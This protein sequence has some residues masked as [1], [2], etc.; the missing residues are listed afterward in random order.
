MTTCDELAYLSAVDALDLFR[1]KQLSPVELMTA[2]VERAEAVEPKINAFTE[3]FFDRALE[4]A[5]AAADAYAGDGSAARPLEGIAVAIKDE[6]SVEGLL[7]TEGSLVH[8]GE[9]ATAT[10][11]LAQ[12]IFDAGGIMHAR[13]TTPEFC[14]VPFT[15][16][17]MWGVTVSPW[18]LSKSAGGS[19]GGSGAAL[20]AGTTT[21][22]TGS[23]IG[24]SIRIPAAFCGVVGLKPSYGR[25]PDVTPWNLDHYCQNGPMA[26]TVADTALL[27]DVMQGP[28]PDD[29][30]TLS[31]KLAVPA[32]LPDVS[33]WRVAMCV[34]LG[35]YEVERGIVD[36]L[37]A[38]ADLLR[39]LGVTVD[40]VEL[41]W[42][43]EQ[44]ETIL[45]AHFGHIAGASAASLS[46]GKPELLNDYV[47]EYI[48]R[49]TGRSASMTMAETFDAETEFYRPLA[50]IFSGYRVL[51][52]PTLATVSLD[53]G[54]PYIGHGPTINGK[55]TGDVD[56]DGLMTGPFNIVG[57]CPSTA[58]PSGFDVS[59]MP[60][61]VQFVARPYHDIDSLA[62]AAAVDQA[63]PL[64]RGPA[65]RPIV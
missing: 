27:F 8:A 20:A 30:A 26:R 41:P 1:S 23:D 36:N 44:I 16:S 15:H 39:G 40:E 38:T 18:D 31:P 54:D 13:T 32:T 19:S 2:L 21:L 37:R 49:S 9:Y 63:R 60:T 52:C 46:R 4:Q 35:D 58:L 10:H 56:R 24:G 5:K 51:M 7:Q 47:V 6:V 64:Y 17:R 43:R 61:S 33:G 59:G 50:E 42:T 28:H 29:I 22:A 53:A 55:P 11:P 25:V 12:R 45:F 48:A 62:V 65:A 14:C 3:Q 34:T 57:R